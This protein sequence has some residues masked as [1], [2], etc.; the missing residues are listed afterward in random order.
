M[1]GE[2]QRRR[3]FPSGIRG[4]GFSLS[5]RL[6]SRATAFGR[7]RMSGR[8]RSGFQSARAYLGS[9]SS[10]INRVTACAQLV[11]DSATGLLAAYVAKLMNEQLS[12]PTEFSFPSYLE[13]K[14]DLLR[15]RAIWGTA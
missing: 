15:L 2:I 5:H 3:K 6:R 13:S 1:T 8:K 11:C 14:R 12:C 7:T 9:L 4:D 10:R